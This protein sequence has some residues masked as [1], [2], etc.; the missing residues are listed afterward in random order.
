MKVVIIGSGNV[1][2]IFGKK[3]L[4]A[5]HKIIQIVGRNLEKT[6]ELAAY[7]NA[8]YSTNLAEMSELADIYIIAVSDAAISSIAQEVCLQSKLLVHTAGAVSKDV[9]AGFSEN[10]GIL[11][12]LQT[13]KGDIS[14]G[15]PIPL[16]VDANKMETLQK[17]IEFSSTWADNVLVADD[18][19]RLKFHVA[20]VFVNNFTNHL[21]T[22][23]Q[24]FCT[25]N[26]LNFGVLQPII[27]ETVSRMRRYP[28]SEV[29]TGPA[30]RK[31]FSTIE[32]HEEVL[33]TYPTLLHI[34]KTFTADIID[35]YEKF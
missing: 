12:P 18:E 27:E 24:D 28:S 22:L 29:Q 6:Q 4:S 32:R 16:L 1:A 7:L 17:V 33:K 15:T 34:Y 9:L 3:I 31:D 20:A 21:F 10:Y 19:A 23:V 14:S 11:Y 30:I 2:T 5:G 8:D 26:D 13:L 35:Y 25:S